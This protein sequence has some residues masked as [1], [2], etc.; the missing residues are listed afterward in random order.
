VLQKMQPKVEVA[1]AFKS[2]GTTFLVLFGGK[3]S[4][5]F[6]DKFSHQIHH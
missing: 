2:N 6:V 3:L 1:L 5:K 4:I